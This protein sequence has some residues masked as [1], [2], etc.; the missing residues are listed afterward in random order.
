MSQNLR[1]LLLP[2]LVAVTAL[3]LPAP[4][5]AVSTGTLGLSLTARYTGGGSGPLAGALV[6][7]ENVDSGLVYPVPAYG[8]PSTS[9]YYHAVSLPFGFGELR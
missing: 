9:A 6:T 4:A 5:H 2:L 7:A 1:R 3:V 8:D